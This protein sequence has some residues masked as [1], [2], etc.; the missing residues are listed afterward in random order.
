MLLASVLYK[1][2]AS[3]NGSQALTRQILNNFPANG[4]CYLQGVSYIIRR[5]KITSYIFLVVVIGKRILM[6]FSLKDFRPI[7]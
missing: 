6:N 2:D 7:M 3:Y 1:Y 5:V 4:K